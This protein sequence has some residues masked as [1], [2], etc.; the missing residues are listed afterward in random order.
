MQKNTIIE[1]IFWTGQTPCYD[2]EEKAPPRDDASQYSELITGIPWDDQ[3]LVYQSASL[4]DA[5]NYGPA[6]PDNFPF[7]NVKQACWSS[8]TNFSETD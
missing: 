6:L 2:K 5:A 1:P 7:I 8:T 4:V 3:R